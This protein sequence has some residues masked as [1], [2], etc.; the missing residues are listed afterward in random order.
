MELSRK[1]LLSVI[2]L[3]LL[4]TVGSA[5]D[6]SLFGGLLDGIYCEHR[7]VAEL[8]P[9]ETDRHD[10][11]QSPR[12]VGAG[13]VQFEGGYSYFHKS[14]DGETEN[15]HTTPELVTRIGITE[16]VELRLRMNYVWQFRDG[17]E[18]LTDL[19]S[20]EDIRY[21]LKLALTEQDGWTPE[22]AVRVIASAPTGGSDFTTSH[23][24]FGF[25]FVYEWR[26]EDE[27]SLAGST[28]F[29]T[30]G[31][32][33]FSLVGLAGQALEG[34]EGDDGGQ[35]RFTAFSQSVACGVPLAE[36]TELYL[37]YFGIYSR[38]LRDDFTLNFFNAG[39]DYLLTPDWVIDFRIGAGL[40]EEADDLFVGVGGAYRFR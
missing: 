34:A 2:G 32:G 7:S 27:W 20:A 16:D 22:S 36:R 1:F 12:T 39:V 18:D 40:N 35:D 30:D 37:E 38:G 33:E 8:G 10:F 11:T 4:P 24:E 31:L 23:D 25:D 14:Q 29:G 19:D 21:G 13:V 9:I 26:N 28:G 6:D 5:G 15:S 3:C 17:E